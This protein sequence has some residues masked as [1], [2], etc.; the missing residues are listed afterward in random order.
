MKQKN[1][2]NSVAVDDGFVLL[3]LLVAVASL[4]DDLHLLHDRAF[5]RLASAQQQQLHFPRGSF[6]VCFQLENEKFSIKYDFQSVLS[7]FTQF[8]RCHL[9][10]EYQSTQP[11]HRFAWT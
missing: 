6:A 9:V 2:L 4:V 10:R 11:A 1:Y 7:R 3:P 8:P 5:A